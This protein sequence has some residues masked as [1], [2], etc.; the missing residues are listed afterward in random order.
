M[1]QVDAEG[2]A[3]AKAS[4]GGEGGGSERAEVGGVL[5]GLVGEGDDAQR[6]RSVLK[7]ITFGFCCR[8][9]FAVLGRKRWA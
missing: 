3:E 2:E 6:C 9:G 7:R 5:V 4:I 1:R 8:L